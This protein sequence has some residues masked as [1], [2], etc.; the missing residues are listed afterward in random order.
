VPPARALLLLL[1]ACG[2]EEPVLVGVPAEPLLAPGAAPTAE[3]AP[4]AADAPAP[5]VAEG[6][7]SYDPALYVKP[8]G[9]VLDV[10]LLGGRSLREVKA[11]VADQLGPPTDTLP[12]PG[13]GGTEY[14]FA[15][16]AVLRAAD[17][18]IYLLRTPLP[19]PMRRHEAFAACG[20]LEP[21]SEALTLHRE[22]R[23]NN[24]RGFRRLRLKR[25]GAASEDVV[26]LEAWSWIPGEHDN[27]R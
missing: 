6:R 27:R 8:A 1:L 26:E 10:G 14:R 2:P 21:V 3:D 24:E 17:D 12:L 25:V 9:V 4:D 11:V 20:L 7:P 5:R 13:G 22:Y 23:Y 18:R 19:R 16:G 15:N